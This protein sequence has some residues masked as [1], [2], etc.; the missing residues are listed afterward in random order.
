MD[1]TR[2]H[3]VPIGVDHGGLGGEDGKN[4]G[5]CAGGKR[6]LFLTCFLSIYIFMYMFFSVANDDARGG[7]TMWRCMRI[8]FGQMQPFYRGNCEVDVLPATGKCAGHA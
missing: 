7:K 6:V 3:T 1:A 5:I 2:R 4:G 8:I